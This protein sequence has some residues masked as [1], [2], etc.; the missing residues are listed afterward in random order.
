[1]SLQN[2]RASSHIANPRHHY[3]NRPST[4][5]GQALRQLPSTTSV[6][7]Q[8]PSAE[9]RLYGTRLIVEIAGKVYTM[10]VSTDR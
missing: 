9:G 4:V 2:I 1:M 8:Y 10:M 3:P 5:S 6:Q 7:H